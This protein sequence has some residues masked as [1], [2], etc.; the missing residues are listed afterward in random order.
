ML[1]HILYVVTNVQRKL[2]NEISE[3]PMKEYGWYT[4]CKLVPP[5]SENY[6]AK[7]IHGKRLYGDSLISP[8][9][10]TEILFNSEQRNK[11]KHLNRQDTL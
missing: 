6:S 9:F 4:T 7:F 2:S 8:G 3:C 1:L 11:E 10:A 5:Y